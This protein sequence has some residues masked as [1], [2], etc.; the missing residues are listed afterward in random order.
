MSINLYFCSNIR[1]KPNS[2]Y[3]SN[4]GITAARQVCWNEL[5]IFIPWILLCQP[6]SDHS[7][8]FKLI[9]WMQYFLAAAQ[10]RRKHCKR[11]CTIHLVVLQ[12][13]LKVLHREFTISENMKLQNPICIFISLLINSIVI[14][15]VNVGKQS[16]KMFFRLLHYSTLQKENSVLTSP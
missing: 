2:F 9:S 16:S 4:F 13:S 8:Q 6:V 14:G 11:N 1:R 5:L 3:F 15:K 12:N 10:T 7:C